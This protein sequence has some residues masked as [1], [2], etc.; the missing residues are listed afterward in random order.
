M[1]SSE[2]P[3]YEFHQDYTQH[4]VSAWATVFAITGPLQH[5]YLGLPGRRDPI[6]SGLPILM[7]AYC[8]SYLRTE[9]KKERKMNQT[10]KTNIYSFR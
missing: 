3:Y 6:W 1:D 4:R 10:R 5:L 9:S 8:I 2:E 7:I